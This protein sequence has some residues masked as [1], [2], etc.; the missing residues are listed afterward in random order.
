VNLFLDT[1]VVLSAC[2]SHSGASAEIF[3]RAAAN[4][5]ILIATPYVIQ[6]ITRNLPACPKNAAVSWPNFY[7]QLQLADDILSFDRPAVFSPAKD[8]PILFS[9]FAYADVLLTLDQGD[10]GSIMDRTFYG[11]PV[12]RPGAFLQRERQAGRLR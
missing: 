5:W 12:L 10:F 2:C 11:L 7:T 8:R 1:S 3:R 4:N 6:E 9:A